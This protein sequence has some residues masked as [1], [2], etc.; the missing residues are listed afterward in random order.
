[1]RSKLIV[2]V[3][4]L[5]TIACGGGSSTP[6]SPS[7][8]TPTT[9]AL[10]GRVTD[11]TTSTAI[12]GAIVDI[13]DPAPHPNAGKSA[14]TDASG[15]YR[16]TGLESSGFTI[17]TRASR[18]SPTSSVVTLTSDQTASPRLEPINHTWNGQFDNG[19]GDFT[20]VTSGESVT[21]LTYRA[22]FRLGR[23]TCFV[24]CQVVQQATC[25][26]T[27]LTVR[28]GALMISRTAADPSQFPTK[29]RSPE[30]AAS[31]TA[32]AAAP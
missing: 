6:A 25:S 31:P 10:S 15:N 26:P 18:Y 24:N 13:Q 17:R 22:T 5:I 9:F 12:A 3:L 8:V 14:T 7:A 19:S 28:D 11:A 21:A 27:T 4:G 2:A 32:A 30:E 23:F 29:D 1:M 16:F 20:F